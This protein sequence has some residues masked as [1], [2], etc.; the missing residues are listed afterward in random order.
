MFA[1]CNNN[2]A[3]GYDPQGFVNWGGVF[4]G[5]GLAVAAAVA[6]ALTVVTAGSAAPLAA[7]AIVTIGSVASAA[8]V[9][10]SLV[11]TYGAAKEEVVVYDVTVAGGRD[12]T[13][14]SLVY[15]FEKNTSD[16]YAH[17]GVQSVDSLGVTFG[18]G[19]V[20]NYNEPGDYGGEFVDVSASYEYK[21]ASFGLDYCADPNNV[22]NGYTGCHALLL[23]SG[24]SKSLVNSNVVYS[25]DYY[26]QLN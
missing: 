23:T 1:Y 19:F 12:R 2:P 8:L 3:M 20:F 6:I 7:Y 21:G 10:A 25:Y 9:E 11:T 16:V 15:D 4:V 26:W 17:T 14:M 24:W 22:S 5:L 13:G 18:S